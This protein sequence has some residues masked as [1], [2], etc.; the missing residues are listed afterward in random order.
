M[1]TDFSKKQKGEDGYFLIKILSVVFV[2]VAVFL[3]VENVKL[4]Q[5]KKELRAQIQ[6]Y[7]DQISKIE[8]SNKKLSNA[9][10]NA[11][12]TE[13][14]EKVAREENGMQKPGEK[15]VSFIMPKENTAEKKPESNS[16]VASLENFWQKIV[17]F[18]K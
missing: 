7:S 16:F 18:F 11:D 1:I 14:I 2:C 10:A 15:V 6:D 12:N 8:E 9:I 3:I 5:K 4:S 13:Y 17:D